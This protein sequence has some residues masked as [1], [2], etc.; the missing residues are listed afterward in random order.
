M[1]TDQITLQ[2]LFLRAPDSGET[3]QIVRIRG[4]E[5]GL[6]HIEITTCGATTGWIHRVQ[7]EEMDPD[8][9]KG[10]MA[11]LETKRINATHGIHA[12]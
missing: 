10:E 12:S 3:Q 8:D 1:T 6:D 9:L 2:T 5:A 7:T 4:A 11:L